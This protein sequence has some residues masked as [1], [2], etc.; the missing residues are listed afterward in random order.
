MFLSRTDAEFTDIL[1]EVFNMNLEEH[2]DEMDYPNWMYRALI[3][4]DL[5][6]ENARQMEFQ[7]FHNTYTLHDSHWIGI[8][9]NVAYEQSLTMVILW[10][11]FWLPSRIKENISS[12]SDRTF[13]FIKLMKAVEVSMSNYDSSYGLFQR[14]ISASNIE[15]I[16]GKKFL[17]IDDV[18]GGQVNIIYEGVEQFLAIQSNKYLLM[19]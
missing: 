4:D 11:E 2:I 7:E 10:D 9:H 6:W 8:F 18:L 12:T 19:L 15:E 17:A 16:A 5:P 1:L 3:E 14:C 13:L